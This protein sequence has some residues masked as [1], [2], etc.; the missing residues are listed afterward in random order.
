MVFIFTMEH[1]NLYIWCHPISDGTYG[2]KYRALGAGKSS[3]ILW[4]LQWCHKLS[5]LTF[6]IWLFLLVLHC[7]SYRALDSACQSQCNYALS[8]KFSFVH[9]RNLHMHSPA[10]MSVKSSFIRNFILTMPHTAPQLGSISSRF[11][12]FVTALWF[13]SK[14]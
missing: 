8:T 3:K 7:S 12:T 6:H 2:R 10:K 13:V 9:F 4:C 14:L 11:G 1:A 5:F